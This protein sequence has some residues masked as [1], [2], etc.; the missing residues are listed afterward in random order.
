MIVIFGNFK[1]LLQFVMSFF[2]L[3]LH[4]AKHYNFIIISTFYKKMRLSFFLL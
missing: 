3:V 4:L 1:I 2:N